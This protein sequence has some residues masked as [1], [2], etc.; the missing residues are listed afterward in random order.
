MYWTVYFLQLF[1]L[2]KQWTLNKFC[3]VCLLRWSKAW[4]RLVWSM[5]WKDSRN[6]TLIMQSP[7]FPLHGNVYGCDFWCQQALLVCTASASVYCPNDQALTVNCTAVVSRCAL[8]TK[9]LS[10][11]VEL[12]DI[13]WNPVLALSYLYL[14]VRGHRS[15]G[16]LMNYKLHV[17]QNLSMKRN[18]WECLSSST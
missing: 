3:L 16:Y 7:V 9:P 13:S 4:C 2:L 8:K 11:R 18:D 12:N 14:A 10:W 5:Y 15:L 6:G 1:G 17:S